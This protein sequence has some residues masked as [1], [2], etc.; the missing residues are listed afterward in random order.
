[1]IAI[2][3]IETFW[4]RQ[5]YGDCKEIGGCEGLRGRR[6]RKNRWTSHF[7]CQ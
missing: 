6:E 3:M 4:K 5:N 1:M 7:L 2:Y